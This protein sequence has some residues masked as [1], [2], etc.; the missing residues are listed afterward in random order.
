MKAVASYWKLTKLESRSRAVVA[1]CLLLPLRRRGCRGPLVKD[2]DRH[3]NAQIHLALW[4]SNLL[5]HC[6]G[7]RASA[8]MLSLC[9]AALFW[10]ACWWYPEGLGPLTADC[11]GLLAQRLILRQ[12]M[13]FLC[14]RQLLMRAFTDAVLLQ[15]TSGGVKRPEVRTEI[16][17]RPP[18]HP[19]PHCQTLAH[20]LPNR[21]TAGPPAPR[22]CPIMLLH[23]MNQTLSQRICDHRF[24]CPFHCPAMKIMKQWAGRKVCHVGFWKVRYSTIFGSGQAC[25]L[26]SARCQ[27]HTSLRNRGP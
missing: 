25:L 12:I 5:P 9:F 1:L 11:P 15:F 16:L 19:L 6:N 8:L 14:S 21:S 4:T 10:P 2:E 23:H 3:I 17:C 7:L 26:I 13:Q 18:L 24:A 27:A 22:A 20:S